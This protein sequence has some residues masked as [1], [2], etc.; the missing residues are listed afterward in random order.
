MR[1]LC[2]E[3]LG[4]LARWLRLLGLDVAYRQGVDDDALLAQALA[5]DCLL[6]TRDEALA[7]RAPPGRA[8]LVR[9]LD[10]DAQLREVVPALPEPPSAA[11]VMSRCS[12]CNAALEEVGRA[13]AEGRVPPSVWEA[14]ERYWRCPSCSRLY[15]RGT[16]A[17][18]IAATLEAL[19]AARAA[20][21]REP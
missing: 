4:S 15:W 9:A 14:H 19:L 11:G 18:R 17:A 6:L 20:P 10:T 16:H 3:M 5:E 8:L 2:D 13:A 21:E 12:L 7:A 1:L